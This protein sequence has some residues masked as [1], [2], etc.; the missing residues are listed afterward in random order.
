MSL[1]QRL[2]SA[3]DQL[4]RWTPSPPPQVN[5]EYLPPQHASP[6]RPDVADAIRSAWDGLQNLVAG[7]GTHRDKRAGNVYGFCK[8]MT[9][10]ELDA[11]YRTSWLGGRIVDTVADDMTRAWI[12]TSWEG[13]DDDTRG[14]K[15]MEAGEKKFALRSKVNQAVKW[16]RLYGGSAILIGIKGQNWSTPLDPSTVKKGGLQ[17]L[18]VVDRWRIS[19]TGALDTDLNSPN[20]GL[21]TYYTISDSGPLAQNVHWTRVVRFDGRQLPY[22]SFTANGYWHD[23]ELER[24][25]DS[26]KDY[27]ATKGGIASMVFEANVDIIESQGLA[28]RLSTKDGE[29]S[30]IKRFATALMMKSFNRT[31]L[32]DGGDA[33]GIGKETYVQKTTQFSGVVEVLTKFMIDVCGAADIPMTRLFGQSPGGLNA[34]GESDLDNYHSHVGAKQETH[35]RPQLE[36]IEEVIARSE[37]GSFPKNFGFEFNPLSQMSPKEKA[38]IEKLD[39]QRDEI[40]LKNSVLTEGLVARELKEKGVYSTIEDSDVKMA[41]ELA[42]SAAEVEAQRSEIEMKIAEKKLAD[43]KVAPAAAPAAK[44]DPNAGPAE[45]DVTARAAE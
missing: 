2:R 5:A 4:V 24:V 27:D 30:I 32:L 12:T 41:E 11:L 22:Y 7:I 40:Y 44:P 15:A 34:T 9:L 29:A 31:L 8:A 37:M 42:Q 19:P 25:I 1:G 35:L 45:E 16:A 14:V 10:V 6:P 18:H 3:V 36:R 26:V 21:P 17:F 23:S 38:E 28:N 39:A 33:D 13:R 43:P 20:L